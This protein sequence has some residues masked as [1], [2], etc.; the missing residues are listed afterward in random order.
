MRNHKK[1]TCNGLQEIRY[2]GSNKNKEWRG[3]VKFLNTKKT[4]PGANALKIEKQRNERRSENH[5]RER[6]IDERSK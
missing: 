2:R 5:M 6:N 4:K 3:A 1:P